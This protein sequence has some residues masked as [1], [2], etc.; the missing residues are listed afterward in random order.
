MSPACCVAQGEAKAQKKEHS[1][2]SPTKTSSPEVSLPFPIP[3]IGS[4]KMARG[5]GTIEPKNEV[6]Y[7]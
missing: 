1:H 4:G 3:I 5:K 7:I 6:A 2:R